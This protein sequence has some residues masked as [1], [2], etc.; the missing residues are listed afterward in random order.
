MCL[1]IDLDRRAA[2]I[3]AG[4]GFRRFDGDNYLTWKPDEGVI[5]CEGHGHRLN[6]L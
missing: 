5:K 1:I 3:F 2:G 6:T 4:Q